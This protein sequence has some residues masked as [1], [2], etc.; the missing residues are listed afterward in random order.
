MRPGKK[1][2]PGRYRAPGTYWEYNDVRINQLSLALLHFV[3]TPVAGGIS[4]HRHAAGRWQATSWSWVGYDNAWIEL[5]GRKVQSVP[6][7]SL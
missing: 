5:G 6:G 3:R 1:A 2:I 7:G 4:R